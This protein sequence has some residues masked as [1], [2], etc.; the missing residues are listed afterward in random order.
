M[1]KK[2]NPNKGDSLRWSGMIRSFFVPCREMRSASSLRETSQ[3][4]KVPEK[5]PRLFYSLMN[6]CSLFQDFIQLLFNSLTS[7]VFSYN[8][9]VR[10]H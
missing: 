10:V 1:K 2:K 3:K 6:K 4:E 5:L 9:S 7:E 8:H